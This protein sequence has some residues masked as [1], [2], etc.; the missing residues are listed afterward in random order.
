M[1]NGKIKK[2]VAIVGEGISE[3]AKRRLILEGF[4]PVVFP[5]Y[6]RLSAPVAN[7][8]DMLLIRIF[9]SVISFADYCNEAAYAFTDLCERLPHGTNMHFIDELPGSE[10]PYDALLNMLQIGETLYVK[11]DT[12]STSVLELARR[13][14]LKIRHT[15]QG[16]PAC[17]VLKL[18]TEAVITADRGIAK[19]LEEDG[20]RVTLI[21]DG[22]IE[23]L[24]Y[25]YGF[26]GGCAGVFDGRVYFNGDINLHPSAKEIKEAIEQE[27]MEV[28]CLCE[29][30]LRDIGGILLMEGR[31]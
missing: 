1:H 16:Y 23:L 31:L 19:V 29:G 10:Y 7:H 21:E 14:R 26:I 24:P 18:N 30:K 2:A 13:N 8:I 11:S 25:P 22:G 17:T 9:D 27:G 28:V 6:S 3:Q 15:K 20:V 5:K 4:E 12:A